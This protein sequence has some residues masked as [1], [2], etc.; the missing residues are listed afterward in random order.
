[1]TRFNPRRIS[2]PV[3]AARMC[4]AGAL[5]SCLARVAYDPTAPTAFW[6]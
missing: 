1:M 2:A 4:V 6:N 5:P 3:A